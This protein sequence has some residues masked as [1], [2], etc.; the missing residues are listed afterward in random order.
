MVN[1][2]KKKFGKFGQ[3]SQLGLIILDVETAIL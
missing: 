2:I 3:F 1:N